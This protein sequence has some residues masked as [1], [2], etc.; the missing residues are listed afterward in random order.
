VSGLPAGSQMKLR[1][2][3]GSALGTRRCEML[4]VGGGR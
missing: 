1:V 4:R 2:W 3:G